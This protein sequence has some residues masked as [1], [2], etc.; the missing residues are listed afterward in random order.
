MSLPIRG[1]RSDAYEILKMR[2][3]TLEQEVED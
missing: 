3:I 2:G 1:V